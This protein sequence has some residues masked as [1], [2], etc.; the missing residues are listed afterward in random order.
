MSD[1]YAAAGVDIAEADAGVR[2]IVD[3]LRT[4]EPGR[5]SRSVLAS[6]HYA[7][8]LKLTSDLGLAVCCDGV[9]TKLLVAEQTGRWDTVGI[10]C[11]AMN[12]N[13]LICV[14]AEPVALVDYI[15]VEEA[16]PAVLGRDRHRAQGR[17]RGVGDRDPGRRARADPRARARLRPDRGRLR[18]RGPRRDRHRRPDRAR[19]R[20]DRH[21]VQRRALQRPDARAPRPARPGR[22]RARRHAG[23]A[24]RR[25]RGRRAAR[26]DRDLR[27]RGARAARLRR[28]GPRPG[29]HHRRRPVQPAAPRLGDRLRDRGSAAR[30]AGV[31]AD[32]PPRRRRAGRDGPRLQHGLRV[33]GHRPGRGGR[34]RGGAAR[35]PPPRRAPHRPRDRPRR[36][37]RALR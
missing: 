31:R 15:A 8:V 4:I 29:P 7:S 30:P 28:P 2:A 21:P 10:D 36:R 26:A 32:P 19:R 11:V 20:P 17:R 6:G 3:V 25:L 34:G 16:D 13:D 35:R 18:H 27:A 22:P 37:R 12:V 1:A 33:R 9:G 14:G 23:R 24:R 5:P